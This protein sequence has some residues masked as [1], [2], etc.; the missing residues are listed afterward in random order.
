M[1]KVTTKESLYAV[2]DKLSGHITQFFTRSSD[3]IAVRDV[4][5]TLRYPLKDTVLLKI[6]DYV[7]T[8][9]ASEPVDDV[10]DCFDFAVLNPK[11]VPWDSYKVPETIA[12]AL[13]P[14]G[15]SPEEVKKISEEKINKI[16]NMR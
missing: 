5:Y 14:L 4:I 7:L 2:F 13:A 6:V 11:V 8:V 12:E 15:L 1:N 16:E 10:L 3:A 9:P